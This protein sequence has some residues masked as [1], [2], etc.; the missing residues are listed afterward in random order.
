MISE[1]EAFLLEFT[2]VRPIDEMNQHLEAQP[3]N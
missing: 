2:V 1:L 3:F